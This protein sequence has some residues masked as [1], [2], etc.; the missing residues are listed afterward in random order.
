[1]IQA[2][3][4]AYFDHSE[5]R[6]TLIF[7]NSIPESRQVSEGLARLG[8]R[9]VHVDGESADRDKRVKQFLEGEL[10]CLSSVNLFL[11]GFDAPHASCAIVARKFQHPS[12][13]IQ[14]CGRMA[15]P[16]AGK[17][18]AKIID[19]CGNI[20]EHGHPYEA[21]EYHLEDRPITRSNQSASQCVACGRVYVVKPAACETTDCPG[22]WVTREPRKTRE[23]KQQELR[24]VREAESLEYKKKW[25]AKQ[26]ALAKRLGFK[27]KWAPMQFK[28]RYGFWP[29]WWAE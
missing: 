13:W 8:V 2:I 12:T 10:A 21:R 26:V 3:I 1:M 24:E 25:L 22:H 28:S 18:D 15:R 11:E 16:S 7:A 6:P 23:Q 4:K 14:A 17:Y 29:S 5:A 27:S 9:S 20:F 19:L